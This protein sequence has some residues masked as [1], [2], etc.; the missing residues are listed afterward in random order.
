MVGENGTTLEVIRNRIKRIKQP[1]TVTTE[2]I[3][4]ALKRACD[5][6]MIKEMTEDRFKLSRRM[7]SNLRLA[8]SVASRTRSR[9]VTAISQ[10]DT[11][12]AGCSS[13][14]ES[15][16]GVDEDESV[17]NEQNH[18]QKQQQPHNARPNASLRSR[19]GLKKNVL[20]ESSATDMDSQ[21]GES[22]GNAH[23]GDGDDRVNMN[24]SE[25]SEMLE[26]ELTNKESLVEPLMAG[27]GGMKVFGPY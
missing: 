15:D 17:Q 8:N 6:G 14:Q 11:N 12:N 19:A 18:Q 22:S 1:A 2:Q 9:T 23:N 4:K 26:Q 16:S 27:C 3:R 10:S 5:S 24:A 13:M 21:K 20:N 25:D 7:Q